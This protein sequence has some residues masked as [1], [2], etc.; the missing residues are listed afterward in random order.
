MLVHRLVLFL[1]FFGALTNGIK[2]KVE[3]DSSQIQ[4]QAVKKDSIYFD[5][6][7]EIARKYISSYPESTIVYTNYCLD[8]IDS[9]KD[10]QS[11]YKTLNLQAGA[12]WF[13]HDFPKAIGIYKTLHRLSEENRQYGKAAKACNNMGVCYRYSGDLDSA[14]KYLQIACEVFDSIGN[15]SA[16][17]KAT[18]DLGGLYT[19]E[20]KYDLAIENLIKALNTFE[21]ISDTLYLIHGYNAIANLYL[22]IDKYNSAI[23]FYRKS[24]ALTKVYE[25]AD[26]STE[27]YCNIGLA[28]YQGLEQNDSAEYYLDKVLNQEGIENNY[29][30]YATVLVNK[31]A[32]ENEKKN[33]SKAIGYF[34]IVEDLP[35]DKVNPDSKMAALINLGIT[36]LEMGDLKKSRESL[37]K[38]LSEAHKLKALHFQEI[39]YRTLAKLDSTEGNYLAALSNYQKYSEIS[40]QLNDIETKEKIQLI[41]AQ[42]N[43]KQS[44]RENQY[45][46]EQNKLK[47]G[48]IKKHKFLNLLIFIAL[49]FTV[50]ILAITIFM[51]NKTRKLNRSLNEKNKKIA[52]QAEELQLLNHQ[53]NKL[54]SI[55]AHDLKGPFSALIGLLNELDTNAS[56]YSEEEK[57]SIIKGL[58]QNA[59]N[60][61]SLLEN[62]MEWSVSKIGVLKINMEKIDLY[63]IIEKVIQLHNLQLESKKLIINNQVVP[64]TIV[65]TDKKMLY[66]ILTNLIS[67]A[68]KFS[69]S[70]N[71]ITIS[72]EK[73]DKKIHVYISDNGVGIPE[74]YINNIFLIDSDYQNHGTENEYGTGL[75]L[76]VVA[77]FIQRLNEEVRVISEEGVGSTFTFTLPAEPPQ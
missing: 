25:K 28:Y 1:F 12:Y 7:F 2:A 49:V 58:L 73:I 43:M 35:D 29:I 3:T 57:M 41:D 50:I 32:L 45:L 34:K 51:Y 19:S 40:E 24:L 22:N 52:K 27:L 68:I 30:I 33:Y 66:T 21:Q 17:A 44:I 65:Y 59:R 76:K 71:V 67:N 37:S 23:E 11:Y 36:Y 39:A 16:Y 75:G 47:Q 6:C 10:F 15:K 63:K 48:L 53:L 69:Y 56:H 14:R 9:A 62:L 8:L 13:Q 70:N 42:Y 77:E 5:Q 74:K 64:G 46:K 72:A 38:G 18:L 26:I 55:I 60:T 4:N 54:I 20:G 31:G 61:Y